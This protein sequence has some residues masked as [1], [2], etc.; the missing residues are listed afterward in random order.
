M[1][2]APKGEDHFRRATVANSLHV[3]ETVTPLG[4]PILRT[5]RRILRKDISMTRIKRPAAAVGAA[6]LLAFSLTAC[7]GGS[8]GDAP[9]DASQGDFCDAIGDA[10]KPLFSLEGDPNEDQFKEFQDKVDELSDVGTPKD[11][12]DEQR[13]GFEIFVDAV[14]DADYEDFTADSENIPGVSDEDQAKAQAF[15]AYATS[16]CAS[17]IGIPDVPSDLPTD[18]TDLP[19]DVPTD[20]SDIPTDLSDIPSDLLSELSDLTDAP[21]S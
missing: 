20:L 3:A 5:R 13:E 8:A 4:S 18:L 16:T 15:I 11:L 2:D 1:R 14:H 19:S 17:E 10:F 12:S 7:G 9:D 21:T 6:A